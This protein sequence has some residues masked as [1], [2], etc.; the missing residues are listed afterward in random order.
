M[1]PFVEMMPC[2]TAVRRAPPFQASGLAKHGGVGASA[3]YKFAIGLLAAIL[4]PTD[5]FP[6]IARSYVD[7]KEN[8]K[9]SMHSTHRAMLKKSFS[10]SDGWA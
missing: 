9:L 5:I 10:P 6:D 2:A 1:A 8:V 3:P 4:A 7:F